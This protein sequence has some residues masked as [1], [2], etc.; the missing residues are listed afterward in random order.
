MAETIEQVLKRV[1]TT[2][3]TV[4]PGQRTALK[5]FI[6]ELAKGGRKHLDRG[7][8]AAAALHVGSARNL[9]QTVGWMSREA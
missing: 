1:E 4:Q 8:R 3:T 2:M 7:E 6:D 9:A 5:E